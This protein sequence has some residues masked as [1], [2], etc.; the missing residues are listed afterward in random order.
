MRVSINAKVQ[1]APPA[2]RPDAMF[3]IQPFALA[4]NLQAGAVDKKMQRFVAVD[5]FRQDHQAAT[6][7]TQSRMI[8]DGDI[9]RE[10]V[11]NRSQ[12]PFGLTKRLMAYQTKRETA[13]CGRPRKTRPAPPAPG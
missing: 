11:G 2:A 1:L 3:L 12:H 7:T 8:R 4:V 9:N 13:L 5:P 6:A 10:H